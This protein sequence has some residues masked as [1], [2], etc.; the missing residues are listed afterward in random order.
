MAKL[1]VNNQDLERPKAR[2]AGSIDVVPCHELMMCEF[3]SPTQAGGGQTKSFLEACRATFR[4]PRPGCA[5][6]IIDPLNRDIHT[7]HIL[8]LLAEN[9]FNLVQQYANS[10]QH[11]LLS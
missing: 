5:V 7:L 4:H 1:T 11:P 8:I 3:C 9:F 10:I 6:Y 2:S